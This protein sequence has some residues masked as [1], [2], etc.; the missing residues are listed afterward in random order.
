MTIGVV[1]VASI[2]P[3]TLFIAYAAYN[4][5][6]TTYG[7]LVFGVSQLIFSFSFMIIFFILSDNKSLL[8]QPF[9]LDNKSLLLDPKSK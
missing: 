2:A 1:E 6:F 7:I 3:K 9:N 8:L 5:L 4:N